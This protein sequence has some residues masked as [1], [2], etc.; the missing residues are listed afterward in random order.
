MKHPLF[1]GLAA[2]AA[3]CAALPVTAQTT[4]PAPSATPVLPAPSAAP[5]TPAPV[6]T[7]PPLPSITPSAPAVPSASPSPGR[8]RHAKAAPAP[9]PSAPEETPSPPAFASLDGDWEFV[10]S[11]ATE[12]VYSR[13]ILRQTGQQLLGTWK[14]KNK[15]YPVTGEYENAGGKSGIRL[16]ATVDGKEWTMSGYVDNASDM[17]GILRDPNG[18]RI[19]FTA[20]H[21][22]AAKQELLIKP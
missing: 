10:E 15:S 6:L 14:Q 16:T 19:V 5:A 2:A 18:K 11:S 8:G 17:I 22:A 21:R 13:L 4:P 20:N 9:T 3:L 1:I 7:P 12:D